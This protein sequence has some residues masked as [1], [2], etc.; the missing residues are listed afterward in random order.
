MRINNRGFAIS[1]ILF[2]LL[3]LFLAVLGMFLVTM[4]NS[5]TLNNKLKDDLKTNIQT[6]ETN[7]YL[8]E[9][10]FSDAPINKSEIESITFESNKIV[11]MDAIDS[12]DVSESKNESILAWYKDSD[13]DSLYEL[14]VGQDGGVIAN[15]N[16]SNLF[17]N[18][19]NVTT[20][21]LSNFDIS[22]VNNASNMFSNTHNLSTTI[23][24]TNPNIITYDN[25]FLDTATNINSK[26]IVNYTNETSNLVDMM[27]ETKSISSNVTKGTLQY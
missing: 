26:I 16:S 19:E 14:Y 23:S 1:Y 12:F 25:I 10:L 7:N 15:P 18:L 21:D 6:A 27:I 8:I 11:P 9:N 2:S 4:N 24:I 22:N 5:I 3:I 17:S 13:S 20:I